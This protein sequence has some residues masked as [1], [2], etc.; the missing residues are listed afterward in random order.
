MLSGEK[1]WHFNQLRSD[2]FFFHNCSIDY[3][4][5]WSLHIRSSARRI[6][7]YSFLFPLRQ[8]ACFRLV[9]SQHVHS[10]VRSPSNLLGAVRRY[11]RTF[12]VVSTVGDFLEFLSPE[13][14]SDVSVACLIFNKCVESCW[15]PT[16]SLWL[17]WLT[18][19]PLYAMH[20][21]HW[22]C[23]SEKSGVMTTKTWEVSCI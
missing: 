16:T 19:V 13:S 5:A 11:L 4:T 20:L 9:F 23:D 7:L 3:L 8:K 17:T 22:E 14:R 18:P 21:R 10:V 15:P 2:C 1:K 12:S 6:K